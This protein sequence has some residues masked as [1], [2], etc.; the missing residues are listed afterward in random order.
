[1][2]DFFIQLRN[3]YTM[4][5]VPLP[6]YEGEVTPGQIKKHSQVKEWIQR[7]LDVFMDAMDHR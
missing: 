3:R 5:L 6:F 7:E 1:M 4:D 2:L